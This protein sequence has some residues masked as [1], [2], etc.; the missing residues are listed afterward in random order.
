MKIISPAL[1]LFLALV[2]LP[3]PSSAY[4]TTAQHAL[5]ANDTTALFLIEFTFGHGK[6]DVSI[7][8]RA[9]RGVQNAVGTVRFEVVDDEK[10]N[11]QGTVNS[12]ILS[13]ASVRE[14][15]YVIPRGETATFTLVVFYTRAPE[16][17]ERTFKAQVTHLPFVFGSSQRLSLNPSELESYRTQFITLK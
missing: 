8:I 16:E 15:M 11:A 7:P 17:T 12:V 3:L 5:I 13:R 4:F 9:L 1:F 2:I 6:Y 10:E 14:G